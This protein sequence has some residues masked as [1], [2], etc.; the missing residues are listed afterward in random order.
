[1][2]HRALDS[3]CC[4]IQFLAIYDRGFDWPETYQFDETVGRDCMRSENMRGDVALIYK[5]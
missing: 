3:A 1:M 2:A 4:D 5:L